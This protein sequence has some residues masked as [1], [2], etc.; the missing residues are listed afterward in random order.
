MTMTV[1]SQLLSIILGVKQTSVLQK[2]SEKPC[3]DTLHYISVGVCV[4]K[5]WRARSKGEGGG[6]GAAGGV[7]YESHCLLPVDIDLNLLHIFCQMTSPHTVLHCSSS[8]LQ[9]VNPH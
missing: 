7:Q 4:G 9:A 3:F 1:K 2:W 8:H 6:V 5:G